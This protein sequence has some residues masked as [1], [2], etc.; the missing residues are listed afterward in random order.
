[1]TALRAKLTEVYAP[2]T[3]NRILTAV[4]RVLKECRRL[5]YMPL[6]AQVSA[7]DVSPIC[8]HRLPKGRMLAAAEL[9]QLSISA[10]RAF[11]QR[12]DGMPPFW[13]CSA[14]QAYAGASWSTWMLATMTR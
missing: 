13:H 1:M 5:G 4:R 11:G 7:G 14:G 6:E 8:G 3:G 10:P 9:V 12:G 2:A